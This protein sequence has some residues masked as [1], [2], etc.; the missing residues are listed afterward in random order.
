[1]ADV[2]S[3]TS[4]LASLHLKRPGLLLLSEDPVV[5]VFKPSI[6]RLSFS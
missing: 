2:I 6:A 4:F 5:I 3:V 1:M